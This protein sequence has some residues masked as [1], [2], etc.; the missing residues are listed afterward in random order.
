MVVCEGS[1]MDLRNRWKEEIARKAHNVEEAC[2]VSLFPGLSRLANDMAE[3]AACIFYPFTLAAYF[4]DAL[5]SPSWVT[6]Q[7]VLLSTRVY[8]IH[9][10]SQTVLESLSCPCE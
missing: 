4:M 1:R 7:S 9:E 6:V 2:H 8:L 3:I 5:W 10:K